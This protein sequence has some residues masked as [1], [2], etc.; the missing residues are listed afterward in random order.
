[1]AVPN[2][3]PFVDQNGNLVIP[4]VVLGPRH[5]KKTLILQTN[6][7]NIEIT[8]EAGRVIQVIDRRSP[9]PDAV[10]GTE[11]STGREPTPSNGTLLQLAE[12]SMEFW[13]N[14]V[15]DEVWNNA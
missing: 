3:K 10:P 9:A 2:T 14:P 13:D 1:M 11:E 15:D 8:I 12:S 4:P 6:S 7:G 5:G